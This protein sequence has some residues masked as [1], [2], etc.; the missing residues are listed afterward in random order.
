MTKSTAEELFKA[1][2][3]LARHGWFRQSHCASEEQNKRMARM[4]KALSEYGK[5]QVSYDEPT[6]AIL[7]SLTLEDHF[8]ARAFLEAWTHGETD[9]WPAFQSFNPDKDTE[10]FK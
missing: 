5:N 2:R 7:F 6:K 4:R 8:D 1:A 10:I 3:A 9:D